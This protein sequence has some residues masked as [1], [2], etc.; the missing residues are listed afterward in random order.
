VRE[1]SSA[2]LS[3]LDVPGNALYARGSFIGYIDRAAADIQTFGRDAETGAD[4]VAHVPRARGNDQVR[5]RA[6]AAYALN[7]DIK[8][9]RLG[10]KWI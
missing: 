10:G 2:T 4:A 5:S 9:L 8:V 3:F 6:F 7:P 1:E